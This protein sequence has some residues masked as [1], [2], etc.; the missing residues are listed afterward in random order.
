LTA[1]RPV[2]TASSDA[3]RPIEVAGNHPTGGRR[4]GRR[5]TGA[6]PADRRPLRDGSRRRR[7]YQ[8][9][10][11]RDRQA[12][13]FF[14]SQPASRPAPWPLYWALRWHEGRR[15]SDAVLCDLLWGEFALKP[16][17]PGRSL[18]ELMI[19]VH[20]RYG[21]KWRIEDLGRAFCIMPR[22]QDPPS[23]QQAQ[24]GGT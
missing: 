13:Q 11:L 19:Y 20:K 6:S 12:A 18:R 16:K 3:G 4:S 8:R 17:D 7:Q 9:H 15:V 21:D 5:Q 1:G 14:R 2:V 23:R 22:V 24:E 10:R